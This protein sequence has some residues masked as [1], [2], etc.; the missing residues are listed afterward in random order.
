[1]KL[2]WTV[3]EPFM[4]GMSKLLAKSR[5]EHSLEKCLSEKNHKIKFFCGFQRKNFD[6]VVKI[7]IF[8]SE[9]IFLGI[10]VL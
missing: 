3:I 7:K 10:Y 6:K 1:M 8:H 5:E 9:R 4:T 2:F